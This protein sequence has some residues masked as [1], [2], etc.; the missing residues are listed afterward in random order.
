MARK[1]P[2]PLLGVSEVDVDRVMFSVMHGAGRHMEKPRKRGFSVAGRKP[3]SSPGA[4]RP[5]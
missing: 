3:D 5:A 2:S 4:V 1:E